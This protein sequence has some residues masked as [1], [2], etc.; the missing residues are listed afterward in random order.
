MTETHELL[1][2]WKLPQKSRA[3]PLG[4]LGEH[5]EASACDLEEPALRVF[6]EPGFLHISASPSDSIREYRLGSTWKKIG[7][8]FISEI[9][10]TGKRLDSFVR[11]VLGTIR[12]K[13]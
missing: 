4:L 5:F 9:E 6:E 1:K 2:L 12:C 7:N 8:L 11:R 3:N 13:L 10:V